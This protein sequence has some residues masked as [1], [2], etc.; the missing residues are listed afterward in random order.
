MDVGSFRDV[1]LFKAYIIFSLDQTNCDGLD[2][3]EQNKRPNVI[4]LILGMY[5]SRRI[6][7]LFSVEFLQNMTA[8][9]MHFG[10]LLEIWHITAKSITERRVSHFSFILIFSTVEKNNIYLIFNKK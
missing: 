1:T 4:K 7:T 5:T 2:I 8:S 10:Y 3:I 9:D 6:L